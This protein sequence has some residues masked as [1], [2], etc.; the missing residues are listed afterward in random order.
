MMLAAGEHYTFFCHSLL[1]I[2]S[3]ARLNVAAGNVSEDDCRWYMYD[4]QSKE[5]ISLVSLNN[6]RNCMTMFQ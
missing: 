3:A 1:T 2:M 6:L 4:I 5:V